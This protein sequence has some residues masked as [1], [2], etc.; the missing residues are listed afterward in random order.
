MD[1][2]TDPKLKA[3]EERKAHRARRKERQARRKMREEMAAV[4]L[5]AAAEHAREEA[6]S[7]DGAVAST[8]EDAKAAPRQVDAVVVNANAAANEGRVDA[9][10]I[11]TI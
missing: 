5:A 11:K 7:V 6:T 8:Y 1:E 3:A 9:A 2:I 4:A 10:I